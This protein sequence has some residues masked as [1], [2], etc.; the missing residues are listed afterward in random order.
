MAARLTLKK[1]SEAC[2]KAL[3]EPDLVL[4]RGNG[5]FFFSGGSSAGWQQSGVYG[6]CQLNQM[7]LDGWV[8]EALWLSKK[9]EEPDTKAELTKTTNRS[10]DH[11]QGEEQ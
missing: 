11:P 8:A 4:N 2:A 9:E 6:A 7:D 3:N 10:E 1:I 5:Y